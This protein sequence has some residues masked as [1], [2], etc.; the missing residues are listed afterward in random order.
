MG[1]DESTN[2]WFGASWG[3]PVNELTPH[4]DTPVDEDCLWCREPIKPDDQG[5]MMPFH[6]E[7]EGFKWVY[8][9]KRCQHRNLGIERRPS[10]QHSRGTSKPQS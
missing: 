3:A 6:D 7:S 2:F 9:H 8:V 1:N 10:S 4:V 5:Y